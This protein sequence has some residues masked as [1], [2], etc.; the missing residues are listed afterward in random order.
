[1]GIVKADPEKL[2]ELARTCRS[3]AEQLAQV[4]TALRRKLEASGWEDAERQK[5]DADF[6]RTI[7]EMKKFTEAL[8]EHYPGVL[9]KKAA[10]L[11]RYQGGA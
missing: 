5:F 9:R 6:A 2:E 10:D 11:R 8:R 4:V 3:S 7:G 1:M